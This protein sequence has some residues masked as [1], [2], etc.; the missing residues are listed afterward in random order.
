V[1]KALS[2]KAARATELPARRARPG[3]ALGQVR[4]V[5]AISL[6]LA[7]LAGVLLGLTFFA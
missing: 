4:Y 2:R 6:G 3:I 5:L 7:A 1:A